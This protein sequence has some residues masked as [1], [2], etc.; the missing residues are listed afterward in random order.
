MRAGMQDLK[1]RMNS[2]SEIFEKVKQF[3]IFVSNYRLFFISVAVFLALLV[4]IYWIYNIV[5]KPP[6]D[7]SVIINH[8][9]VE[10]EMTAEEIFYQENYGEIKEGT[11]ETEISLINRTGVIGVA[12]KVASE[13]NN[14]GFSVNIAESESSSIEQRT[15]IIFSPAVEKMALNLSQ[16]L[17]GALLSAYQDV[18]EEYGTPI[19]IMVG[20]DAK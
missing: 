1:M 11:Q 16:E 8:Q 15:V 9:D 6:S 4:L 3:L 17:G 14:K 12:A 7:Y 5:T 18:E 2:T 10:I 20:E 13:L 19:V